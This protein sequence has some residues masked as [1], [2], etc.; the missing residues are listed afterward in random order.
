[1]TGS[2]MSQPTSSPPSEAATVGANV[3]CAYY[4]F[5]G[6]E[7]DCD[8][9]AALNCVPAPQDAKTPSIWNPMAGFDDV[10]SDGK[11]ANIQSISN[12]VGAARAH[13]A[14]RVVGGAEPLGE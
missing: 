8:H 6:K 3:S 9:P 14:R 4:V 1:M 10:R 2:K 7:P 13:A 5:A 12:L 11:L